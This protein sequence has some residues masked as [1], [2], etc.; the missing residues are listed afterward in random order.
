[1]SPA[2]RYHSVTPAAAGQGRFCP[3]RKIYLYKRPLILSGGSQAQG[4]FGIHFLHVACKMFS[5][6]PK[7]P[8]HK[9]CSR[10]ELTDATKCN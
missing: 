10:S 2:C 4:G 1:M 5:Y 8:Y 6:S 3:E 9:V 7:C